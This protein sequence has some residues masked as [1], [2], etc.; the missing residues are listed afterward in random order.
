MFVR[1]CTWCQCRSGRLSLTI[2]GSHVI[3]WKFLKSLFFSSQI[4][5][6]R[7]PTLRKCNSSPMI[8]TTFRWLIKS[9]RVWEWHFH[10]LNRFHR[11]ESDGDGS[12]WHDPAKGSER[13]WCTPPTNATASGF[14]LTPPRQ[15]INHRRRES[16]VLR[17]FKFCTHRYESTW[18]I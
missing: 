14:L 4:K 12:A 3:F 1:R 16:C 6:Y 7:A 2:W 18:L 5:W 13:Q 17:N 15:R 10:P 9:M 11:M 8:G